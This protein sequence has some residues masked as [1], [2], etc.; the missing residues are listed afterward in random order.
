MYPLSLLNQLAITLSLFTATGVAIHDT[1]VDK[2][3]TSSTI[4]ITIAK[5]S[6]SSVTNLAVAND[7]HT[8]AHRVSLSQAVQDIQGNAPRIHPREDNKKHMAQKHAVRGY[9]PFDNY[10]LPII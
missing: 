2:A 10:T 5:R 1:K 7:L 3:F 8:H 6:E 9:H 4:P